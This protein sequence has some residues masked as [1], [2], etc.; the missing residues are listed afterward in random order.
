[1]KVQRSF[2]KPDMKMIKYM[3]FLLIFDYLF[4]KTVIK[5]VLSQPYF[6]VHYEINWRRQWHSTPVLL[7]GKSHGWRSLVGCSP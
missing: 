7:P 4:Q 1:M 5:K 6:S 3:Q 2:K